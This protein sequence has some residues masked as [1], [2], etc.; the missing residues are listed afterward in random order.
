MGELMKLLFLSK[1]CQM[2]FNYRH[3]TTLNQDYYLSNYLF[4]IIAFPSV[5]QRNLDVSRILKEILNPL[6][7]NF[8]NHEL[9]LEFNNQEEKIE[10]DNS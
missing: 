5:Y 9:V 4:S 10:R 1:V 7:H 6:N 8:R 3:M 2:P